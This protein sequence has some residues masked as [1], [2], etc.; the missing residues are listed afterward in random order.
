[1]IETNHALIEVTRFTT[2]Q[3]GELVSLRIDVADNPAADEVYV[4]AYR[5]MND[6]P[7]D[8]LVA[9]PSFVP[10]VGWNEVAVDPVAVNAGEEIWI[11]MVTAPGATV[12]VR[13]EDTVFGTERYDNGLPPGPPPQQFPVGALESTYRWSVAARVCTP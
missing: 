4:V 9:T 13:F 6:A 8:L 5:S 11:G 10:K 12:A 7:T 3:A 2:S 1:M